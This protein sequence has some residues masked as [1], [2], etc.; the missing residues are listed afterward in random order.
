MIEIEADGNG[1]MATRDH[2]TWYLGIRP[3]PVSVGDKLTAKNGSKNIVT[4]VTYNTAKGMVIVEIDNGQ[5][6]GVEALKQLLGA[7]QIMLQK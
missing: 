5:K 6:I 2:V 4:K 7:G 1:R 3:I